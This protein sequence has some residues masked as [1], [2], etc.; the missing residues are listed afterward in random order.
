MVG[1]RLENP[2][3]IS[4]QRSMEAGDCYTTR[5]TA[6]LVSGNWV[7]EEVLGTAEYATS[8]NKSIWNIVLRAML[9]WD[10]GLMLASTVQR[11]IVFEFS[12]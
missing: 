7:S 8:I 1:A 9:G 12:V 5:S 4:R 3:V 10:S 11:C 2:E 6:G